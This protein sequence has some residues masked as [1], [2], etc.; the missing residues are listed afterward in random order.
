MGEREGQKDKNRK[1]AASDDQKEQGNRKS[2]HGRAAGAAKPGAKNTGGTAQ[3]S[4][5]ANR[6]D[7]ENAPAPRKQEMGRNQQQ[8]KYGRKK[9]TAKKPRPRGEEEMGQFLQ[10]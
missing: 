10:R 7:M 4:T 9:E 5:W 6:G 3:T 8:K 2:L 1:K